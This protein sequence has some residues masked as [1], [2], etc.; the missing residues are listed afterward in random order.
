MNHG[1]A[2]RFLTVLPAFL[3][4]FFDADDCRGKVIAAAIT[5]MAIVPGL[6]EQDFG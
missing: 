4:A 3:I 6:L 1:L 2:M 5:D